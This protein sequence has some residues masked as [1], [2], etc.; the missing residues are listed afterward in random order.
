ME[1]SIVVGSCRG[2]PNLARLVSVTTWA[3]HGLTVDSARRRLWVVMNE[4][5][6][7]VMN[8]V[9][10]YFNKPL[11][12]RLLLAAFAICGMAQGAS[13]LDAAEGPQTNAVSVWT[14][15]VTQDAKKRVGVKFSNPYLFR[16]GLR[17]DEKITNICDRSQQPIVGDSCGL[18]TT[19]IFKD[20]TKSVADAIALDDVRVYFAYKQ[21]L[22]SWGWESSSGVEWIPLAL[23]ETDSEDDGV[24]LTFRSS[25]SIPASLL[26]RINLGVLQYTLKVV[27]QEEGVEVT[28]HLD[29]LTEWER[30][31]WYD[32]VD[33]NEGKIAPSA[34]SIIDSIAP[35]QA[36]INEV[37]VYDGKTSGGE[38]IALTNQYIEIAVPAYLD[39]TGWKLKIIQRDFTEDCLYSFGYT[40]PPSST[41]TT[42][43]VQFITLVSPRTSAAGGGG[44][45][46]L[47][48]NWINSVDIRDGALSYYSPYALVLESPSGIWRHVAVFSGTNP[49]SEYWWGSEFEP[50]T[51]AD[52]FINQYGF[53]RVTVLGKDE[54]VGSLSCLSCEGEKEGS[55]RPG[56]SYT[57]ERVNHWGEY[58]WQN[59]PS[60]F[61]APLKSEHTMIYLNTLGEVVYNGQ[62][63]KSHLIMALTDQQYDL[64]FSIPEYCRL[65]S[66]TVNGQD[67]VGS[68]E[69]IG[70]TEYVLPVSVGQDFYTVVIDAVIREDAELPNGNYTIDSQGVTWIISV[71]DGE[72]AIG[73]KDE[74]GHPLGSSAIAQAWSLP[75]DVELPGR[76]GSHRITSIEPWAV[77]DHGSF[78][79]VRI[80]DGVVDIGAG[81]FRGCNGLTSVNIP[82]GVTNIG[83]SAFQFCT[84]LQSIELPQ[85]L[86]SIGVDAFWE[87]G[88]KSLLIPAS[89]VAISERTF[90]GAYDISV[91]AGNPKFAAKDGA[92]YD[93]AFETILFW[94][95][96]R[97]IAIPSGVKHIA[98]YAFNGNVASR[99]E[100]LNLPNS[101]TD[102]G[103]MAFA[104]CAL[105]D[106]KL[107]E[108][109]ASIKEWAFSYNN[110]RAVVLPSSV[111]DFAGCAFS[112]CTHLKALY[113]KG[114]APSIAWPF[115]DSV[116]AGLT[117]YARAGS[118]GWSGDESTDLPERWP[119]TSLTE[120]TRPLCAW[121]DYPNVP[122]Y[123]L[124]Q[125]DLGDWIYTDD[126]TSLQQVLD[127]GGS[128][129]APVLNYGSNTEFLG[130]DKDFSNVVSDMVVRAQYRLVDHNNM[131]FVVRRGAIEW[132]GFIGSEDELWITGVKGPVNGR[133]TL[134]ESLEGQKISHVS[135]GALR[136][137]EGLY[138][139]ALPETY[140]SLSGAFV[141]CNTLT[142]IIVSE[143]KTGYCFRDGNLFYRS[144][145][146][147][148]LSWGVHDRAELAVP[149]GVT[150]VGIGFYSDN[151]VIKRVVLPAS[152]ENLGGDAFIRCPNLQEIVV[153]EGCRSFAF[154]G[155]VLYCVRDGKRVD[156]CLCLS[157]VTSVSISDTVAY[158]W[159][160][161]F[162][163]NT[164]LTSIVVPASVTGIGDYVFSGC[165]NLKSVYFE[166]NAPW[167][168]NVF[169][170]S[171]TDLFVYVREGSRGWLDA[172]S[173]SLPAYWPTTSAYAG[174]AMCRW[175]GS[176][177]IRYKVC[178]DS[179]RY[180]ALIDGSQ[181]EQDIIGGQSA[182]V[183]GISVL[184]GFQFLGW[185]ADTSSVQS[186]MCVA[187]K[188]KREGA[189][190]DGV[191][192]ETIGDYTWTF[193]IQNCEARIG[194]PA[195]EYGSHPW[196]RAV[197][198]EPSG[199][200][201]IPPM[202][203]GC[204]VT[205]I[206][207]C[208]LVNCPAV[209]S[210]SIPATVEVIDDYAF[211][212]CA[213]IT[214]L[215]LPNKLRTI[216]QDAFACCS[217][218]TEATLPETL[219]TIGDG[220][221][222]QCAFERVYIPANVLGIGWCAF[223]CMNGPG[224]FVEVAADNEFYSSLDGALYNKDRTSLL[225]WPSSK[226]IAIPNGVRFI[227]DNVFNGNMTLQGETIQVPSSVTNIGS[228]AFAYC[229]A[230]GIEF[231]E[232]LQSLMCNALIGNTRIERLVF[233]ESFRYMDN[234]VFSG[235][236][237]LK[238]L[239]F[240]SDAPLCELWALDGSPDDM[241]I[242]VRQES[243]GWAKDGELLDVWPQRDVWGNVGAQRSLKIWPTYP[244]VCW[245]VDFDLKQYGTRIGGG[246]LEQYIRDGQGAVPPEVKTVDAVVFAGWSCDI[247]CVTTRISVAA[248]YVDDKG[249]RLPSFYVREDGDDDA[250]GLTA[251]SAFQSIQKAIDSSSESDIILVDDGTYAPIEV[252]EDRALV[253]RS[254]NGASK[255]FIDGC[256]NSTCA[257]FWAQYPGS[258]SKTRLEGFTLL[259][260][261]P[262]SGNAGGGA[263]GGTLYQ[264]VI[265]NCIVSATN[266][267]VSS[268]FGGGAYLSVLINCLVVNNES[269]A[270]DWSYGGGVASC[271]LY[272]CTV[273]GNRSI[274]LSSNAQG[275]GMCWGNA[276]NTIVAGNSAT[277]DRYSQ[278]IYG[279]SRSEC[280]D[281]AF[282]D[283]MFVNPNGGD[284]RLSAKSPCIDMGDNSNALTEEDLAG[285]PRIQNGIVDIGAYEGGVVMMPEAPS[286]VSATEDRAG[287]IEVTWEAGRFAEGYVVLRA[288]RDSISKAAQVAVVE[289]PT[290]VDAD[291]NPAYTYY[292]WI[293]ATNEFGRSE[294]SESV[295]G[296]CSDPIVIETE[297]ADIDKAVALEEYSYSLEAS[298][299]VAPYQWE[300][301]DCGYLTENR[302]TTFEKCG[303]RQNWR[304]GAPE[305]CYE[306][307]FDFPCPDGQT[308]RCAA[309]NW[310][311]FLELRANDTWDFDNESYVYF[312][313]VG[314]SWLYAAEP[315]DDIYVEETSD[316]VTF[317]WQ[318]HYADEP[319]TPVNC[320]IT[321]NANGQIVIK[322]GEG[323]AFKGAAFVGTWYDS[324]CVGFSGN[325]A[326]DIIL[327]PSGLPPGMVLTEDGEI[328]G[329]ATRPGSY[330]FTVTANGSTGGA[331]SKRLT[332]QVD[333]GEN[334]PPTINGWTPHS[335]AVQTYVGEVKRFK[336]DVTDPEGESLTFEWYLDDELVCEGK[337]VF[338]FVPEITDDERRHVIECR[339]SDGLWKDE[340]AVSHRWLVRVGRKIIVDA[341]KGYDWPEEEEDVEPDGSEEKPFKSLQ[342]AMDCTGVGDV[343]YVAPG[344][345][346]LDY[347]NEGVVVKATGS[348]DETIIAN[349]YVSGNW[350]SGAELIGF[351]LS[352]APVDAV[353]CRDCIVRDIKIDND[354]AAY[355]SILSNCLITAN[356]VCGY[357]I[358]ETRLYHCTVACNV[359]GEG[360]GAMLA[361][362][363]YDSIVYGNKQ[364]DGTPTNVY[365]PEDVA[366]YYYKSSFQN[367]CV[368][369]SQ[370]GEGNVSDDPLFVDEY[371]CD[372]RL[373]VGS[374]A[375]GLG[376]DFLAQDVAGFVISTRVEGNGEV[377][378]HTA[379]VEAGGAA[380]FAIG[381]WSRPLIGFSYNGK[382]VGT[383][384]PCVIEDVTA[385]GIVTAV[386]SNYTFFVDQAKGNDGNDGLTRE[387]AKAT[388][389]AALDA[390]FNG[391]TIIVA[392]G[393]Y[394][395]IVGYGRKVLVVSEEGAEKTIIRS[396]DRY[397]TCANL[398]SR[399]RTK[400][401]P[402]AYGDWYGTNTVLRGFTLTGGLDAIG[403]GAIGGTLESCI[404]SNNA[405]RVYGGG[406]YGSVCRRC[407]IVDNL[408]DYDGGEYE[409]MWNYGG[410]KDYFG[411]VV[412][413]GGAY[414]ATL[415]NCTV[416]C[417]DALGEVWD[418]WGQQVA[419]AG[420]GV[421]RCEAWDS[422]LYMNGEEDADEWSHC[423]NCVTS[424][425]EDPKFADFDARDFRLRQ[426]SPYVVGGR[427]VVGCYATP[428]FDLPG[429]PQNVAASEDEPCVI[430]VTWDA[431]EFAEKY[432]VY[433]ATR[434][435]LKVAECIAE[436]RECEFADRPADIIPEY[437]YW[438]QGVNGGGVGKVS[439]SAIGWCDID[440]EPEEADNPVYD[441]SSENYNVFCE[442]AVSNG[443]IEVESA[444][445]PAQVRSAA[446]A[447]DA[448]GEPV[449]ADFIA[450]TDPADKD[451]VF[452]IVDARFENGEF[453]ITWSPDLNENGT[454]SIRKYTTYGC[455]E[456]GGEWLNVGEVSNPVKDS[457]KFF[458]V[459]VRMK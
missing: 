437:Y 238:S 264:C 130:W 75:A 372:C 164:N 235:C 362:D 383:S 223:G 36:W 57:P 352:N 101:V 449:W 384:E 150:A 283:A 427:A 29:P 335:D 263:Y 73:P 173:F 134:P 122:V 344:R 272:N 22:D 357:L 254:K 409:M 439:E 203:G 457:L 316:A 299:G 296:T 237:N 113:F 217:S 9:S 443:L 363:T 110:F 338:D 117:L 393:T 212:G 293:C 396:L 347:M 319:Q 1:L 35:G 78:E 262:S 428:Y 360:C 399:E 191:H 124:V 400:E 401:E 156:V 371:W 246:E 259:N 125:F 77:A 155:G 436:V 336:I 172:N 183:P 359:V 48:W 241:V 329:V 403:G 19:V 135:E 324:Y 326:D 71:Y 74:A 146:E 438:V 52:N 20:G 211:Y 340:N 132:S 394:D 56:S 86:I 247:S 303:V 232:G 275:G 76:I 5:G 405:A 308:S 258:D 260:G 194:L 459:D 18:Q 96:N 297:N 81:A 106:L 42:N 53:S 115:Y 105:S 446:L 304:I 287:E 266:G 219:E 222:F 253:I 291:V 55:W 200:L 433:R 119:T 425:D 307:P 27:Y 41:T 43:G 452:K 230:A 25:R 415:F 204:P 354:R 413:G 423:H 327:N 2:A 309:L 185:S 207:Y 63:G 265:S 166:G 139:V 32:P 418:E 290:F 349:S 102:V 88:L 202:L 21:T 192:T 233:P 337:E 59:I 126:Y 411:R 143:E 228:S 189:W 197:E 31:A 121:S 407:L 160:F 181:A 206:G 313:I 142:N 98:S 209:S 3:F 89:A 376:V 387:K 65:I 450:G 220:S 355:N 109:L 234:A 419:N 255:T 162:A 289:G 168:S 243:S 187:A 444:A 161:A 298:G 231:Q 60:G 140:I 82:N 369:P 434:E 224:L 158:I 51:L 453:K 83:A 188:Y 4:A 406:V 131:Q 16:D 61:I 8:R 213:G 381:K 445:Y 350:Y 277:G 286:G 72:A 144:A 310:G 221:F 94:P 377:L 100:T 85:G 429:T 311:G 157:T 389:Q 343:I 12:V 375:K 95:S 447:L 368:W 58:E 169:F 339:V 342:A 174:R 186:N 410:K 440:K 69:K 49:Y 390:A 66:A 46:A 397:G 273:F 422:I 193:T 432:R 441:P 292:Y 239:F 285:S 147:F 6:G 416:S 417:N 47:R 149:E 129:V 378:P 395:P 451:D 111:Y 84:S 257:S 208:T 24:N 353:I 201:V 7:V 236:D 177:P 448:K 114:D 175:E 50:R 348:R 112:G 99:G 179:G 345:Y 118:K 341:E 261:C 367:C 245:K 91:E 364:E 153:A 332:I 294:C 404:I 14:F 92:L 454:K 325:H 17:S 67:V 351:T 182:T 199:T 87:C 317:R 386:F 62:T 218:L 274:S 330:A 103:V 391:E 68:V 244:D 151:P 141:G 382:P 38:D 315:D 312:D 282:C 380:S 408:V 388:I 392:P 216:G 305:L 314:G 426:D 365:V 15:A 171:P 128:A 93:L 145:N 127:Y 256:G 11:A 358:E 430:Y 456:L 361:C 148:V 196:Y 366:E 215:A 34:Y 136:E 269:I 163:G 33:C 26:A 226:R 402:A 279:G 54:G 318:G 250:D 104:D 442:W 412:A 120:Y 178:F 302:G 321:L 424:A 90:N 39:L 227:G 240:K 346:M 44:R 323:N 414:R 225:S 322:Y 420:G 108:G 284:F 333:P 10:R 137:C 374:P 184:D 70:E 251:T 170:Q 248:L 28:H 458:K 379:I 64:H 180:G 133:L 421:A 123:P 80:P 301:V 455:S 331:N 190:C 23:V 328:T 116:P 270:S 385:D 398:G 295:R 281:G 79:S 167:A 30:P 271:D 152:L 40:P 214:T 176:E 210:V 370:P 205:A 107:G 268:A 154:E 195:D 431:A 278:N 13:A 300:I 276:F 165:T 138:E 435:D 356:A 198:P 334:L 159:G 306:L 373:R 267:Y 252:T 229:N 280:I 37:N 320:S 288:N 97:K 242:F 45:L 249:Q